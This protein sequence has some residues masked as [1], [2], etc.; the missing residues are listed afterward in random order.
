M[1]LRTASFA[2]TAFMAFTLLSACAQT[3]PGTG[4][5]TS[6]SAAV[7]SADEKDAVETYI[8]ANIG[9]LSTKPA[10]LG[11]TFF[12][13]DIAF[14]TGDRAVVQY[15]DGHNAYRALVTYTMKNGTP[16]IESFEVLED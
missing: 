12:V 13:T 8:R 11:G 1:N 10:Q 16:D 2:T 4:T 6:S 3:T 7:I 5:Q 9:T 15:E 14:R